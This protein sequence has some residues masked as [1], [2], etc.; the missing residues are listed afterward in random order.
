VIAV[1]TAGFSYA[2]WRGPF[3]PP[4]LPQGQMLSRYATRF[5]AV[6]LDY[7][8]YRMPTA[9]TLQS[10]VNRT[11]A[12]FTF[13]VKAHREM[14][15]ERP[16][17][18]EVVAG[19]F[20]EFL[21]A[22][23]PLQTA[24][25]LGCV[26]LQFPW[27]FRPTVESSAYLK[28]CAGLLQGTPAV[29]EFRNAEWVQPD[30]LPRLTGLLAELNLGFCCV[31]EPRL[32]GLMP[33]LVLASGNIGYV[34]F[35]GRNAAKWWTHDVASERYDYLYNEAELTE[36]AEKIKRLAGEVEKTYVFFNNC[37]AGQAASNAEQMLGLLGV[38]PPPTTL[39]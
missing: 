38:Q 31:D 3:Y 19:K 18:P 17:E 23:A 37:H 28:Q 25:R 8:Y 12:G 5:Q 24:S 22:I 1:G 10:M 33:P 2:D 9:R 35:H 14:T 11:G 27:A 36:W 6:E 39:F 20:A 4:T 26:L 16:E 32:K 29:V 13:C 21:T 30:V 7:T 15:H 34:R